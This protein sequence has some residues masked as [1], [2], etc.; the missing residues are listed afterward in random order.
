MKQKRNENF[1]LTLLR[2]GDQIDDDIL[3]ASRTRTCTFSH[4]ELSL[5]DNQKNHLLNSLSSNFSNEKNYVPLFHD[6]VACTSM[7]IR[8]ILA[9]IK[10]S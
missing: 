9:T 5:R 6:R 3:P 10:P 7:I 4:F 1:S 2:Q 8:A